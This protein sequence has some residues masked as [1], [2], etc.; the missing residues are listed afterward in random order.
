MVV[1]AALS[2]GA[3]AV[4]RSGVE[5]QN[6]AL[7]Q[8]GTAQVAQLLQTVAQN[9]QTQLRSLAFFSASSGF[10]PSVFDQQAKALLTNPT[11]SVAVVDI[12]GTTPKVVLAE[13]PDLHAGAALP[14]ALSAVTT[15]GASALSSVLVEI[16]PTSYLALAASPTTAPTLLAVEVSPLDRTKATPNT[17]GPYRNYYVN[18]YNGAAARPADLLVTTFGAGPLQAP[19]GS[20]VV[21]VGRLVWLVQASAKSPPAGSY[22]E[23][24][25]WAVL[26]VGLL[27]AL[28]VAFLVETLI[29]RNLHSARLVAERTAELVDAQR[30]VVRSERLAA[31]GELSTVVGHELRNPLGAAVNNLFLSR[32]VLGDRLT[33]E[34]DRYL[35]SAERE[36]H[37]AAHL[38][39]DLTAYMRER[40][41]QLAPVDFAELVADVLESTP[42]P[43]DI[44]V[45]VGETAVI[46]MDRALMAQVLT[47]VITNAYQEMSGGGTLRLAA[48][49]Q[50]TPRI[51]VQDSGR[52]LDP[53][54]AERIFDPFFTTKTEGTGLG[55]AIVHRLVEVQGG[56]VSIENVESGGARV[57]IVFPAPDGDRP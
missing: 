56:S 46:D 37:R 32:M 11:S 26:G 15:G 5:R 43:D 23:A 17:S 18:L 44:E 7:V 10:S 9:L 4:I 2:L 21:R 3:W 27:V 22:A 6:K 12:S 20:A 54:V 30:L 49:T 8:N 34:A 31:V 48:R 39:E 51:S 24:S 19:V 57:D 14:S 16:G 53:D 29:R 45:T 38:S 33:E 40:E 55:L 36:I 42:P 35:A 13:G 1:V 50:P 28:A 25:P 47:N 41:P 52:G